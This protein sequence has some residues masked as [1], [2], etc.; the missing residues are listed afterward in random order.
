MQR[1]TSAMMALWT[2]TETLKIPEMVLCT[3][4]PDLGGSLSLV[5]KQTI[6]I[7]TRLL[8]MQS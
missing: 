6:A 5:K 8:T 4:H 2:M 3:K 1:W 7:R